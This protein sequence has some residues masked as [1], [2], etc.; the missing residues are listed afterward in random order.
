MQSFSCFLT[1]LPFTAESIFPAPSS[2]QVVASITEDLNNVTLSSLD[3]TTGKRGLSRQ[4]AM[5]F[6]S[7]FIFLPAPPQAVDS[8]TKDL[9]MDNTKRSKR[10]LSRQNAVYFDSHFKFQDVEDK[11]D[12][13][14]I[15]VKLNA[16]HPHLDFL[17]YEEGLQKLGI[18]YLETANTFEPHFY[19]SQSIGMSDEASELFRERVSKEYAR[20]LLEHERGKMRRRRGEYNTVPVFFS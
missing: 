16:Q 18:Y 20:A 8:G 3:N 15:L 14:A 19:Q 5:S 6:D 2:P 10:G 11:F 1:C 7:D 9:S 17:Q 12:I 13:N 4:N